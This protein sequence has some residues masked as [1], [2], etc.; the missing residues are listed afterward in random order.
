MTNLREK[1]RRL[2]S[3]LALAGLGVVAFMSGCGKSE[4]A[5][6]NAPSGSSSVAND[7]LVELTYPQSDPDGHYAA[8]GEPGAYAIEGTVASQD[9]VR[10]VSVNG[11]EVAP[12]RIE[13]YPS[14]NTPVNVDVYRFRAPATWQ[15]DTRWVV[16]V[17]DPPLAREY[18]YSP[19]TNATVSYWRQAAK[20]TPADAGLQYRLGNAL[21]GQN[22]NDA[23]S[24][25]ATALLGNKQAPWTLYQLGKAYLAAGQ[26]TEGLNRLNSAITSYPT[27]ADAYYDR[28]VAYYDLQR[29]DQAAADLTRASKLAPDWAE[30]LVAL[31]R[32]YYAQDKLQNA[33]DVYA[34]AGT[35][36]PTWSVPDYAL[37]MV[38]L[39]QGR[40][41]DATAHLD[42]AEKL[43]PWRAIHHEQLAEKLFAKGNNVAAWRQVQIAQKL[44]G[45]PSQDFL[46]R[47]AQ[48]MPEPPG[49]PMGWTGKAKDG[50]DADKEAPGLAKKKKGEKVKSG[51][52]QSSN[53]PGAKQPPGQIRKK[54]YPG[55]TRAT[56]NDNSPGT[57][58][59]NETHGSDRKDKSPGTHGNERTDNSSGSDKNRG[60]AGKSGH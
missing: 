45:E 56:G 53:S 13:N 49:K 7:A 44:G 38:Q 12:Y 55:H 21:F 5:A 26:P 57:N 30:P 34:R 19:D 43:G 40:M 42:R 3:Q 8:L 6:R 10:R 33:A 16:R 4:P 52:H 32:I 51:P 29:Y 37:A 17:T 14:Y 28:G 9:P 31:G 39:D 41:K 59:N 25:L 24:A 60:N 58:G 54:G 11:V 47:L 48:E 35:V 1:T 46:N 15:P 36:W 50:K 27:F 22:S 23:I 2:A 18:I 20:A